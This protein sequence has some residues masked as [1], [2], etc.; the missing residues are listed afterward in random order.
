MRNARPTGMLVTLTLI[1][2]LLVGAAVAAPAHA[3]DAVAGGQT[4]SPADSLFPNQGNSG[5]DVSHYDINLKVDV[6]PAIAS[7]VVGTTN[8]PSATTTIDATT[9]DA[10]LSSYSLDFQGSTGNL[11]ASTYDVDTVTVNGVAATFTRIETSSTTSALVDNHKLIIT[12]AT[13]VSGA[14]T[15]VVKT[16]GAPV[17]HFDTD[18][19]AEGWNNTTDGAT[20]VNQPV[21]S[22]TLFPNNNTPRD[23]ATYTF[24]IDVPT[25]LKTSGYASAGGKPY[26]SAVASNGELVSKTPSE[27]GTR[28]TWVWNETKQ[29]ASELSMVSIGRYDVY[30]SDVTLA[31]GRVLHEW[32]FIDPAIAV[33][34]QNTTHVSRSQWK[35]LLDFYESKYGPYPGNSIGVVTDIVPSTI[36]YALETQDRPFFPTSAGGSFYHEVMHQWWGDGVSPTDWNDITLNE[37]PATY[38]PLQFAYEGSGTSTT[39]T[40]QAVYNTY[41]ASVQSGDSR[42]TVAPAAMTAGNQLFG[43][44]VYA[45]GA[46]ALEALRTGIG[47]ANFETLMREYQLTYGGGEITGRR[48]A[49]FKAM[50]E[51]ISGRDLTAFFQTWWF[52]AGKPAWPVKFNLNVAGPTTQVNPGDAVSYTLSAR[53]T[54]KVPM[55]ADGTVITLDV[56]DVLDDATIGALPTGV[57]QDGNKLT[58]TVPATALAA[59]ASVDVP[60]TAN[61]STAGNTLKAVARAS[62]LGSTCLSCT[63]ST[64][65]GTAPISPAPVPTI[66]GGTPTIGI[67]LTADTTGWADGTAFTYQWFL[68]GTP[69]IGATGATYTPTA[70]ILAATVTVKVTGTL[71]GFSPTS[72]TSAATVAGVRATPETSGTPVISSTTAKIGEKLTVD[73]GTWLPGTV[74]TYQWRAN[75]A[76]ITATNGGTSTSFTPNVASQVGQT[77][78][79]IVTG[80]KAGYVSTAKTAAA[81][82]AVVAGDPLVLTPT[83]VFGA[84]TPKVGVA[85][86]PDYGSWDDGVVTTFQWAANGVNVAGTAGT[87]GS[88]IPTAATVGQTLTVTV[89]GTKPGI[90]GVSRP[91]T[92]SSA[93]VETGTQVLQPTPTITGTPRAQTAVT[94]VQGTW[95]STTTKTN[96]WYA[97]GIEISGATATTYTPTIAQIGQ[98]LT[99]EVTSTKPGYFTV[100]KTSAGKTILGLDQLLK[101]TPTITGTPKVAVE[102]TAVA[103]TWDDGTTLSYQWYADAVAVDGATLSTYTPGIADAGSVITVKV[104]STKPTYADASTTSAA[105]DAVAAGDLVNT[106]VPTISGTPKVGVELTVVPG[107]WDTDTALEYQWESDGV[108]VSGATGE[109]YTPD[110]GDL[111]DT[112]TVAVTGTKSGYTKVT[113]TSEPTAEVAEG[114]QFG[115]TPTISGTTKVGVELSAETGDWGDD[116]SFSYQWSVDGTPVDDATDASYTPTAPTVG[117]TVTVA[118]TG[119]KDGYA[120]LTKNSA[121]SAVIAPGDLSS[122]P[123]PTISGTPKVAT[124]L[125]AVPGIWDAGVTLTYAWFV[126]GDVVAGATGS[127]YAV[128]TID[129]GY[130]I[131]VI[132]T[133]TKAGYVTVAAPSAASALVTPGSL[134]KTPQPTITGTKTAVGATLVAVAGSWDSSTALTY[135]WYANGKVITGATKFWYT[136][137]AA[138]LGKTLQV[139]VTG[140]KTHFH[141]VSKASAST[142]KIVAGKL[143]KTGTPSISGT[144]KVHKTLKVKTWTW[145]AGVTFSYRWYA[146]GKSIPTAVKS[147]YNIQKKYQ[148][149]KITVKVTGKKAG[150]VTVVKTSPSTKKVAK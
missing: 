36:N 101:P 55:P 91:T 131:K 34:S 8:L 53:N 87:A 114:E 86:A 97:D 24:T 82:T 138:E 104:T 121:P 44:H 83:P 80:T 6:T 123:T 54:G 148:G 113:K 126:D 108:A 134:V 103:G 150:Y 81:T 29:M 25:M 40:E 84:A 19:S 79:V 127:T 128:R 60:F 3:A 112:I 61:A 74:F 15:T 72:A 65:I 7:G 93:T 30:E 50:A 139:A 52:T 133:G 33:S 73:R 22:M 137:T 59:T 118:V 9:T 117:L 122:T 49:A 142:A 13:P 18:G 5:Y 119:A 135:Q 47:A 26:K 105:T 20:F 146:N 12:P 149:D 143:T 64:V 90:A 77:I 43:E 58:W 98:V 67:P 16:H 39:T 95:D 144:A 37:G 69:V 125:T 17:I 14:F 56:S 115:D 75:G 21:G 132:V 62:T 57:T 124:T 71:A 42:F 78:D 116:V 89:T 46:M 94:G 141:S 41:T 70:N 35:S 45:K 145:D 96:K 38:A 66:T 88:Y 100:I 48:T 23:K 51:E 110:T 31:S 2:G 32:S 120:D 130:S 99:Y 27:D 111:G 4:A 136:P 10:P 107:D 76:N 109:T 140:T 63:A 11:A 129:E 102:L 92:V 68:D 1:S 28:T 106:P 85:I 147:S